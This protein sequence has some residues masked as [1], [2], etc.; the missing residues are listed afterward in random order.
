M[1]RRRKDPLRTLTEEE[2]DVLEQIARAHSEP[3]SHVARAKSLLAVADGKT[4]GEAAQVAGR[5][6]NDAV[7]QLVSRFNQEGLA[8]I[9][10]RYGGGPQ[11]IYGVA[12][13]ER[14]LAEARRTPD[15][16]EGTKEPV[17]HRRG[18]RRCRTHLARSRAWC[19]STPYPRGGFREESCR[20]RRRPLVGHRSHRERGEPCPSCGSHLSH[21]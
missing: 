4:Y 1:T 14:I 7:S 8:A 10:P 13:Q 17:A 19:P 15:R 12:E 5:R 9:E 2:R 11:P 20:E 18:R 6:S 21:S 3:A 16:E